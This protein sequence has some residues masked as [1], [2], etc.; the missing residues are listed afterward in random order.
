MVEIE[1]ALRLDVINV[2]KLLIPDSFT[3]AY[4]LLLFARKPR[5]PNGCTIVLYPLQIATPAP[6]VEIVIGN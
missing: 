5:V 4:Q 1:A 2:L 6:V 3:I